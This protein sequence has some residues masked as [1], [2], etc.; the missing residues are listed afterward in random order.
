MIKIEPECEQ[1]RRRGRTN[2]RALRSTVSH[3]L[4]KSSPPRG[5]CPQTELWK[6]APGHTPRKAAGRIHSALPG[7]NVYSR[8]TFLALDLTAVYEAPTMCQLPGA[9]NPW[10]GEAMAGLGRW[11][12]RAGRNGP[13]ANND[14]RVGRAAVA[15]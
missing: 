9:D 13:K 5:Y 3:L 2:A 15:R 1:V 4:F 10:E 12:A 6:L 8:L 7:S 14:S 11:N